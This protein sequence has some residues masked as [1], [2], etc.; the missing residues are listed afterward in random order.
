M[1][2]VDSA[3]AQINAVLRDMPQLLS[4]QG[5][6]ILSVSDDMDKIHEYTMQLSNG[7]ADVSRAVKRIADS[8]DHIRRDVD[9]YKIIQ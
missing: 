4:E 8:V 1:T 3:I 6:A 9:Q 5:A 7:S 2:L